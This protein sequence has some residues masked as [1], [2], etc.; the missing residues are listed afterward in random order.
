MLA[1][2]R[3]HLGTRSSAVQR[4]RHR[5]TGSLG[6]TLFQRGVRVDWHCAPHL[7]LAARPG[8]A[9]SRWIGQ[10]AKADDDARVAGRG[11]AAIS[12]Y[13]TP[14]RRSTL[15]H[16]FDARSEH[17]TAADAGQPQTKPM[18]AGRGLVDEQTHRA[19]VVADE[20]VSITVVV[21]IAEGRPT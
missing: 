13:A 20:D 2:A 1:S 19:V 5:P 4:R 10:V 17:V 12:V 3:G 9:E 18:M 15:P 16:D 6:F 21:D 7:G 8:H 11:V 14:A